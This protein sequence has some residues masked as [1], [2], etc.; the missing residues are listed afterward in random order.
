MQ[1]H[2]TL[3]YRLNSSRHG[4]A[5]KAQRSLP[6]DRPE[7]DRRRPPPQT[8][9]AAV[10]QRSLDVDG[11]QN[12]E[13]TDASATPCAT[14]VEDDRTEVHPSPQPQPPQSGN[15]RGPGATFVWVCSWSR[16]CGVFLPDS[17]GVIV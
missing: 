15:C 16:P 7:Q 17:L 13:K 3:V 9:P 1:P 8:S 14:N 2:R 6:L 10:R 12:G 5:A 4:N 11:S